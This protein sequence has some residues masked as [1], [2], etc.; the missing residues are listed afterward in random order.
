MRIF[1]F[2]SLT[3]LFLSCHKKNERLLETS[4]KLNKEEFSH[5]GA[6]FVVEEPD[7]GT[8]NIW[9]FKSGGEFVISQGIE[10]CGN[11]MPTEGTWRLEEDEKTI[12]FTYDGFVG[13]YFTEIIEL[14]RNTLVTE[15]QSIAGSD[16]WIYR[17]HYVRFN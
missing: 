6:D 8:D 5:M 10:L 2:I 11:G 13:E 12:V 3:T 17:H 4:W 9:Y 16:D 15:H 1:I 14:T 7:C